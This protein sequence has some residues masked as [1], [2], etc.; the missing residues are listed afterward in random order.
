MQRLHDALGFPQNYQCNQGTS[1]S[2]MEA[3]M[4]LLR[5]LSYPNR[6]CDLVPLFGRAEEE[7]SVIFS[8]VHTVTTK[9]VHL[10]MV[11]VTLCNRHMGMYMCLDPKSQGQY[12]PTVFYQDTING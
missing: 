10:L 8:E 6:W 1:A 9:N 7:L 4:I 3:M 11:V 5:R 12:R 2:S